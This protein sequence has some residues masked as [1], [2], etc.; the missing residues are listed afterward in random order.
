MPSTKLGTGWFVPVLPSK[1]ESRAESGASAWPKTP[2][3][4]PKTRSSPKTS[5]VSATT[6]R[7]GQN[8]QHGEK[9]TQNHPKPPQNQTLKPFWGGRGGSEEEEP[10]AELGGRL[11][12]QHLPRQ[13]RQLVRVLA[14]RRHADGARP[15]PVEVTQLEGQPGEG[16]EDASVLV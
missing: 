4:H 2:L 3:F 13:E 11:V 16:K 15:V 6:E 7:N 14:G 10:V 5:A 1:A 9:K 12:V 8:Q